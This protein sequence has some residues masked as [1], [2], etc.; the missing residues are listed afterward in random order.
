MSGEKVSAVH[1]RNKFGLE[2]KTLWNL[3][4]TTKEIFKIHDLACTV[5]SL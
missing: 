5:E 2:T 4:C 1:D 3:T